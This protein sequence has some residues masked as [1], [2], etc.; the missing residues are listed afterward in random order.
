MVSFLN[1]TRE[2]HVAHLQLDNPDKLNALGKA[3]WTET[4]ATLQ[5]LGQDSDVRA[6]VLRGAG[7]AFSAGLDIPEM[8][9]RLP[10]DPGGGPPDGGRQAALHA[11]IR[12]MQGAI[13]AFE[14]LEVPVIAAV[15]G[16]CIGAGVDLITACDIRLCSADAKFGVRETK[17][18]MVADVGTMQRL[19]RIV[20]PGHARELIYTGR[21]FDAAHAERIGLVNRVLPDP[22]ALFADAAALA[23]E[24]AANPPLT[25]RGAK[26]VLGEAQRHAIDRELE[27]VATYNVGHLITQDLGMAITGALTKQT[28]EFSGR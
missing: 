17:L 10:V 15:H 9:S 11:M 12:Q 19:P 21:D 1:I 5:A 3:F 8:M 18:A 28:P 27:Y 4:A 20:G 16:Y 22:D 25:V 26:H 24:I 14:R 13:T 2:G 6:V 23:A 7:R